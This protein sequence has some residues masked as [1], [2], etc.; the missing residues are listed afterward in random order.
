LV[1]YGGRHL[2]VK[3]SIEVIEARAYRVVAGIAVRDF[4]YRIR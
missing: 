2:H 4:P 3:G 1:R